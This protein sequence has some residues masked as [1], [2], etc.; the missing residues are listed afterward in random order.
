[1]KRF[2]KTYGELFEN[3]EENKE[4]GQPRFDE[5]PESIRKDMEKFV[6]FFNKNALQQV[7]SK[8]N[9]LSFER[10]E[11]DTTFVRSTDII[12]SQL[13]L[14]ALVAESAT[15]LIKFQMDDVRRE[16]KG[17]LYLCFLDQEI[18]MSNI[19]LKGGQMMYASSTDSDYVVIDS[20]DFAI[21][22][23]GTHIESK[24]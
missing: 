6:K 21:G 16:A 15:I 24:K 23:S 10:R 4:A 8:I 5:W 13:G 9:S 11:G 2:L 22:T 7:K 20:S 18:A 17:T 1:M 14:I 19:M 12:S 3:E